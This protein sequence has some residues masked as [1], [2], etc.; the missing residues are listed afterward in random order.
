LKAIGAKN[1]DI[2]FQFFFESG[3]MG[4]IG[5]GLGVIIGELIAFGGI[6]GINNF[7]G[8]ETPF[9]INYILILGALFGSFL[10]GAISG[11]IPAMMASKENP[12]DALR[13]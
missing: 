13:D 1:S 7:I 6:V 12:V 9:Q 3:L 5:G 4:L 11:I 10:V 2:F 8:A